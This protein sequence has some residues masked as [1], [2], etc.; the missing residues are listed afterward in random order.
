MRIR[1]ATDSGSESQIDITPLVDIMFTLIIFFLAT[2]TFE[3]EERDVRVKLPETAVSQTISD[4][5]KVMVIN[6]RED[7]SYSLAARQM[8]LPELQQAVA[9]AAKESPGQKVLV[10]GDRNAL[11]GHVA[12]A[13]F[14]CK[15][16]GIHEANIGYQLPQ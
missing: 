13:V 11:H 5:P 3:R 7:G 8:A 1:R 4:A 10:R 9:A 14:A 12:A 15:Q 16:A 2:S 6:V